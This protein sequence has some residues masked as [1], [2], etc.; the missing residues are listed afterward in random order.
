MPEQMSVKAQEHGLIRI[1]SVD[2]P[3]DQIDNFQDR[4]YDDDADGWPLRDALTAK[5]LDEDFIECFDV[6]VLEE[7]ELTGYMI[8]GLGIS[9]KD[10]DEVRTQIENISGH[11]LV[12]LSN[13]FGG[14]AQELS[15]QAPLKWIGTFKEEG[16]EVK[17][18]PLKSD[19]A[20]G[21][22]ADTPNAKTSNPHLMVLAAIVALPILIGLFALLVWLVLR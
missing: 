1:F 5:Y 22:V 18:Q 12:V 10:V 14:F 9:Q 2:L 8:Q 17:F 16:A 21:S 11:V 20:Q 19:A 15:P 13:A 7:L 4:T 3:A 6:A